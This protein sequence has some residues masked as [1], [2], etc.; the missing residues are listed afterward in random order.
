MKTPSSFL[1]AAALGICLTSSARAKFTVHEW[2]T[3]TVLQT[4][5]GSALNWYQSEKDV[6]PLPEFITGAKAAAREALARAAAAGDLPAMKA[7]DL[8]PRFYAVRMETPVLY[9]YPDA[10]MEVKVTADFTGGLVTETYPHALAR[11]GSAAEWKG[12]LLRPSPE[13]IASVPKADGPD[14]RHYTAARAVPDAWLFRQQ[15]AATPKVPAPAPET[16]HFIFYRG[17]GNNLSRLL[18]VTTG[19]DRSYQLTNHSPDAVPVLFLLRVEG[20]RAVW[21]RVDNLAPYKMTPDQDA[22]TKGKPPFFKVEGQVAVSLPDSGEPLAASTAGLKTAM[23]ASL[24]S[25]GLTKAEAAAMVATW[26][27][28]WFEEPGTR[29]LA[30]LPQPWV[31][32]ILPLQIAP[33][34]DE[35]RRVFVARM[36]TL[37]VARQ[38]ALVDVLFNNT[39]PATAR[40]QLAKLQLGRFAAGAVDHAVAVKTRQVDSEMRARFAKLSAPPPATTAP[41]VGQAR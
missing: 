41:V 16:D 1:L 12:T 33:K 40:E 39:D 11:K 31:D 13:A 5:Q 6:T 27:N 8:S 9:F 36:E 14:G 18:A 17:A 38:N 19:D 4:S 28:L 21:K 20:D 34:P 3:F 10:P 2:G 29:V 25:G 7:M 32:A 23:L 37:P 15:P 22:I 30:V 35:V 26:D 24:E